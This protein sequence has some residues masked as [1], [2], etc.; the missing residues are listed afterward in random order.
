MARLYGC[1]GAVERESLS[2]EK[3][4]RRRVLG[5]VIDG[6]EGGQCVHPLLGE[7]GEKNEVGLGVS[8][9][10]GG[11]GLGEEFPAFTKGLVRVTVRWEGKVGEREYVLADHSEPVTL[12]GDGGLIIARGE[13]T[14]VSFR[15]TT[16][17]KW[18]EG[19]PPEIRGEVVLRV[20]RGLFRAG[21]R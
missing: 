19:Q 13:K 1:V 21:M 18:L 5:L 12:R 20:A 11:E 10:L 14:G 17:K 4:G 2:R 16:M 7:R 9:A 8:G 15:E 6:E 3:Q